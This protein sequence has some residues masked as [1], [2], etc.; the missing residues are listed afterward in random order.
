MFKGAKKGALYPLGDSYCLR[1][2]QYTLTF[3]TSK[4]LAMAIRTSLSAFWAAYTNCAG[5][6]H[7]SLKSSDRL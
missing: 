7:T 4:P 3:V 1:G 2:N 6:N 5:V